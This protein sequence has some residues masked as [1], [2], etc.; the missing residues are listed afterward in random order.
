[1]TRT[2]VRPPLFVCATCGYESAKWLGPLHRVRHMGLGGGIGAHAAGGARGDGGRSG[3]RSVPTPIAQ[4]DTAGASHL[5]TE[6]GEL[7]WV[8]RGVWSR[9]PSPWIGGEPG[10]GGSTLSDAGAG[11]PRRVWGPVPVGVRRGVRRGGADAGRPAGRAR[12]RVVRRLGNVVALG[13]SLRVAYT[14]EP[15]VLAYRLHPS[16]A[17]S[18]CAGRGRVGHP[19]ARR[20]GASSSWCPA[21]END[22]VTVLVGHVT[23]DGGLALPAGAGARGRHGALVRGRSSPRA[24]DVARVERR[25]VFGRP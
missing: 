15:V 10:M 19:G 25:S 22:I 17:R 18:G 8:R 5:P 14:S 12:A 3:L 23:K 4:V 9:A 20:R 13:W 1:M 6:V 16:R 11:E 21:K 7:D 24:A 2:S